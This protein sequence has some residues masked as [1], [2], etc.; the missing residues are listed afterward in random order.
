MKAIK[1]P[2]SVEKVINS[3]WVYALTCFFLFAQTS[4][5]YGSIS[6]EV[7]SDSK[8]SSHQMGDTLK[9]AI[10]TLQIDG[11]QAIDSK[12]PTPYL[13]KVEITIDFTGDGVDLDTKF[14]TAVYL[15]SE[16][17]QIAA[18]D[19]K[20][21]I[22]ND[23]RWRQEMVLKDNRISKDSLP[24]TKLYLALI[25]KK[26]NDHDRAEGKPMITFYYSDGERITY[27]YR[28]FDIR[29]YDGGSHRTN[30]DVYNWP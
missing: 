10:D 28:P 26:P 2:N 6:D 14:E 29:T 15:G 3:V 22:G 11:E 19:Q 27:K 4:C 17:H 5:N 13:V 1:T 23:A 30:Q 24:H 25:Q 18:F 12:L 20:S 9:N 21:S 7:A 8:D 16:I